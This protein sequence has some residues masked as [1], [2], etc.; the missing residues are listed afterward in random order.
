M[1]KV[2]TLRIK[3]RISNIRLTGKQSL[4]KQFHENN[5]IL[6]SKVGKGCFCRKLSSMALICISLYLGEI[7]IIIFSFLSHTSSHKLNPNVPVSVRFSPS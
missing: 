3:K 6:P 2:V 4:L 7:D 1:D 5:Y